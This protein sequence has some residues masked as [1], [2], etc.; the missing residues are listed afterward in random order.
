MG[1]KLTDMSLQVKGL[2][3]SVADN[4]HSHMNSFSPK[5][6]FPVDQIQNSISAI[7]SIDPL[8]LINL[9]KGPKSLE[10]SVV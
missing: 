4:L 2:G 6:F 3:A 7:P 9:L 1:Q 10:T 5:A 8:I